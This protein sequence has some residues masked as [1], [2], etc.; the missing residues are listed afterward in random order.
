[1]ERHR[2]H[3]SDLDG[4]LDPEVSNDPHDRRPHG[5]ATEALSTDVGLE[6]RHFKVNTPSPVRAGAGSDSNEH[7][8]TDIPVCRV[9][10]CEGD[11][12]HPL[13][14]PCKCSGSIRF[15]HQD[16]LNSWLDFSNKTNCE[17]CGERFSF[18]KIYASDM[19][20][21]ISWL[22]LAA[23][24]VPTIVD[25]FE[26]IRLIICHFWFVWI[27]IPFVTFLEFQYFALYLLGEDMRENAFWFESFTDF[28]LMW[29]MGISITFFL[30]FLTL[31]TFSI[32]RI[33]Y[34]VNREVSFTV[35]SI[36][37]TVET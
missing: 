9:C 34:P 8:M 20:S 25:Y 33:L 36:L 15:I 16:C 26:P 7:T 6:D 2:D 10:H 29:F 14:H 18:Q 21:R 27:I 37:F 12:L 31:N 3:L 23:E 17:L 5:I 28:F 24:L 1:M 35:L 19:P 22:E 4:P 11:E 13:F 32:V 30:C